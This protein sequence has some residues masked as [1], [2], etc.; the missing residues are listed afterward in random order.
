MPEE[1]S[2]VVKKRSRRIYWRWGLAVGLLILAVGGC[3]LAG[4]LSRVP[5]SGPR[6]GQVLDA[7]TGR[8]LTGATVEGIWTCYDNPIPLSHQS[9]SICARTSTDAGGS[10]VL[11]AMPETMTVKLKPALPVLVKAAKSPQQLIRWTAME[12]LGKLSRRARPKLRQA[13]AEALEKIRTGVKK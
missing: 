6:S 9:R 11:T 8:P 2:P 12:E 7:G 3:L 13:T 10:F 5:F 1:P 4:R